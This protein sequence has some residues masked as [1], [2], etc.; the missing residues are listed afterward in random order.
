M[1]KITKRLEVEYQEE[2]RELKVGDKI[3]FIRKPNEYLNGTILHIGRYAFTIEDPNECV[4]VVNVN[5]LE[6]II[7]VEQNIW[8]D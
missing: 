1:I 4:Y 8:G 6:Q 2:I 3:T 5:E 7:E